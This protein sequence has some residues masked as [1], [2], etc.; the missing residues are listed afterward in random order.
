MKNDHENDIKMTISK[1][2]ALYRRVHR[3]FLVLCLVSLF[4]VS[5]FGLLTGCSHAPQSSQP[6]SSS[7]EW[8]E[9]K[10]TWTAAGSR[11]IMPFGGDRR[12]A[13]SILN[14]SLVL[15]GS[16]RPY[17]GFR[18][19]AFVFNDTA[20]GM[21]GRAVWTDEHGDQAFSELR[22]E[23]NADNNKITGTFVGGTGRY[24]GA[25]GTYEFSWRFVLE[26]EDGVVEGQSMDLKG[27]VRAGG[28]QTGSD[29][30]GQ[31]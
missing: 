31:L 8:H 6:A 26:N 19:E 27:R 3:L 7:G 4:G 5:F 17:V 9:F 14:G 18:A 1:M 21:V 2:T 24:A 22:G 28:Q 16:S 12:A 23:G 11:N 29:Q 13:M 10:G 20:T 30:G 25:Q 15:A